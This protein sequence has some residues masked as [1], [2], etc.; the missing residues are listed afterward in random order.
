MLTGV[1][2]ASQLDGLPDAERPTAVAADA[3]E[4]AAILERLA[5]G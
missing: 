4:L 1:T 5:S 3:T 2:A